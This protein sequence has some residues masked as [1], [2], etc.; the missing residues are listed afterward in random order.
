[1]KT[2]TLEFEDLEW[3]ILEEGLVDPV[4]WTQN[5]ADVQMGKIKNR[6]VAKEQSRL[7]TGPT[8]T[9]PATIEG[10]V[11]SFFSQ[12]DYLNAAQRAAEAPDDPTLPGV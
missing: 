5:V 7:I 4:A 8:T 10:L 1:M 11:E 3:K 6:I 2:I 12:P 9:M